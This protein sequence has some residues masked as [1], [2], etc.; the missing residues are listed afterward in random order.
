MIVTVG[1]SSFALV[2]YI[3][4][5]TKDL[6]A[7]YYS[8]KKD[9]IALA[10]F[11]L[12]LLI[13]IP[14]IGAGLARGAYGFDPIMV[15]NHCFTG[16]IL[17]N[18]AAAFGV[19]TDIAMTIYCKDVYNAFKAS[20]SMDRVQ[21]FLLK[22]NHAWVTMIVLGGVLIV[23][24]QTVLYHSMWLIW[25]L[26]ADVL[27]SL[28]YMIVYT[29]CS[30]N[31]LHRGNKMNEELK[32]KIMD[33]ESKAQMPINKTIHA[34][35]DSIRRTRK[36]MIWS[37]IGRFVLLVALVLVGSGIY[38]QTPLHTIIAVPLIYISSIFS[39]TMQVMIATEISAGMLLRQKSRKEGEG[40]AAK[41]I[42][43]GPST[44]KLSSKQ[45]V[46][47]DKLPTFGSKAKKQSQITPM[48]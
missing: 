28:L 37:S 26:R 44:S 2:I 11:K 43:T 7:F 18:I 8:K 30:I 6:C 12:R 5:H 25:N 31:L 36:Y 16:M 46:N 1:L 32:L 34:V 15:S 39:S 20:R 27:A 47:V 41:T 21:P 22:Y 29:V 35:V 17:N 3:I 38:L 24:D 42:G 23:I 4:F 9:P 45:D 14:E 40:G 48:S 10:G 13:L 33:D 19:F